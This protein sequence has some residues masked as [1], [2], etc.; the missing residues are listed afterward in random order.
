MRQISTRRYSQEK[1]KFFCLDKFYKYCTLYH[2]ISGEWEN[3]GGTCN[4]TGMDTLREIMTED[5]SLSQVGF[6]FRVYE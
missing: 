4:K 3:L 5:I 6:H 2:I 1:N